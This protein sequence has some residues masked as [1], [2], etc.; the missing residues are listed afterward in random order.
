MHKL[1]FLHSMKTLKVT[2]ESAYCWDYNASN[3]KV[4]YVYG[5]NSMCENLERFLRTDD[6]I[7]TVRFDVLDTPGVVLKKLKGFRRDGDK[8]VKENSAV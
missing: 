1:R 8:F 2:T 6:H 5:I 7:E 4:R 3:H